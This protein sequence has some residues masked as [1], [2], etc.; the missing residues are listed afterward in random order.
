MAGDGGVSV[1]QHD[2]EEGTVG[3]KI[4]GTGRKTFT[5]I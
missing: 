4:Y 1:R 2:G 5:K 3:P